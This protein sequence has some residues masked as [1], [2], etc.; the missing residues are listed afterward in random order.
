MF[1][2]TC[3]SVEMLKGYMAR[4]SFGTLFLVLCMQQLSRLAERKQS[5]AV[6]NNFLRTSK[7]GKEHNRTRLCV[8]LVYKLTTFAFTSS[9][10]AKVE[11]NNNIR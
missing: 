5:V 10:Q 11:A 8:R 2:G 9:K 7:E 1:R 6:T 4:Q 3:S